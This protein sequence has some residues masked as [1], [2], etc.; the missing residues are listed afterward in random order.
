VRSA[1][2]KSSHLKRTRRIIESDRSS[3]EPFLAPLFN[4]ST[5]FPSLSR[6]LFLFETSITFTLANL[7]VRAF[8]QWNCK[9]SRHLAAWWERQRF[10][11]CRR[12]VAIETRI[13]MLLRWIDACAIVT[14]SL[15][16]FWFLTQKSV[17][18]SECE[19][20]AEG[21]TLYPHRRKQW[22]SQRW[23]LRHK[24]PI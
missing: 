11:A 24:D 23:F 2:D 17:V 8:V 9:N 19:I 12:F 1:L 15:Q 16:D 13:P 10:R 14:R 22:S 5:L 4:I 21:I 7:S 6:S 3:A 20:M 18:I